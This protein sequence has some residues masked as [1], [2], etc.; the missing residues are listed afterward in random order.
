[1]HRTLRLAA[2]AALLGVVVAVGGTATASAS[3][4]SSLH[5]ASST[6]TAILPVPPP[7]L[8]GALGRA[9]ALW[10]YK[11][12]SLPPTMADLIR[13]YPNAQQSD[14]LIEYLKTNQD[15]WLYQRQQAVL[16]AQRDS[17]RPD[18][19]AVSEAKIAQAK[20]FKMPAFKPKQ[21]VRNAVGVASGIMAYDYGVQAVNGAYKMAGVDVNGLVCS[22]DGAPILG[23]FTQQDCGAYNEHQAA[24]FQA[25]V[26]ASAGTAWG[27]MCVD[28]TCAQILGD[29]D[30][31]GS[32]QA[33]CLKMSGPHPSGGYQLAIQMP[34][35]APVYESAIRGY[36]NQSDY[37]AIECAQS[38][39]GANG[40][41]AVPAP[42]H[43]S[44]AALSFWLKA[45]GPSGQSAPVSPVVGEADPLRTFEC[46]I[47]GDNGVTYT[48]TS[49]PFKE[50]ENKVASADCGTLP[51]GVK[52]LNAKVV[53]TGGA[54]PQ[55]VY[56]QP[57]NPALNEFRTAYPECVSGGCTLDLITVTDKQSCFTQETACN[58]W[59]TDPT[60]GQ[61]YS[62]TYG[63]HDVELERCSAYRQTFDPEMRAGGFA[64]SNPVTGQIQLTQTAPKGKDSAL[65]S[66]A[67]VADCMSES[68][69]TGDVWNVIFSPVRCALVWAFVPD[70]LNTK[71]AA[72]DITDKINATPVGELGSMFSGWSQAFTVDGCKGP[73]LDIVI[74]KG[75]INLDYHSY[76]MTACAGDTLAPF[77][78]PVR[79]FLSLAIVFLG[80]FAV[81]NSITALF[82]Y[83][84]FGGADSDN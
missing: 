41:V 18:T 62:C 57:V 78:P 14:T 76:P 33:L 53:E 10:S 38:F 66:R 6:V 27:S 19:L 55:T 69:D 23:I 1:M 35:P 70:P 15:K 30:N 46:S 21:M 49:P 75:F 58:G 72:G 83:K 13:H 82:N 59:F 50:S 51:D 63:T 80:L 52:P 24:I 39:P 29:A 11:L 2:C 16:A 40:T 43:V 48:T 61:K 7:T 73:P 54:G 81:I 31:G 65:T 36:N 34:P 20:K 42:G 79:I 44:T 71:K 47:Q 8:P 74:H 68:V 4:S 45:Y 25:N 84:R 37:M 12:S 17:M 77:A 60:R 32:A 9:A 26:D 22:S 3:T 56:D 64:Y 67:T 28:T 5:L